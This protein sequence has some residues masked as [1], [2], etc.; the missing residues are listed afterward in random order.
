MKGSEESVGG[1]QVAGLAIGAAL[2][3]LPGGAMEELVG[4]AGIG[5][6]LV[7]FIAFAAGPVVCGYVGFRYGGWIAGQLFTDGW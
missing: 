4:L 7:D 6:G 2:G 1:A 3:L 5:N